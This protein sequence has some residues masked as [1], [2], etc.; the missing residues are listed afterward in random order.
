MPRARKKRLQPKLPGLDTR[1]SGNEV[2]SGHQ[3][4]DVWIDQIT[5]VMVRLIDRAYFADTP[6][7]EIDPDLAAAACVTYV[8]SRVVGTIGLLLESTSLF[9]PG[10]LA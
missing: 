1:G 10:C 3:F 2:Y 8:R 9:N 6:M 7:D 4:L 5:S